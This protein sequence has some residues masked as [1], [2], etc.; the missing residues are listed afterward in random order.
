MLK[1]F[2][3]YDYKTKRESLARKIETYLSGMEVATVN[4]KMIGTGNLNQAIKARIRSCDA[5]I[6]MLTEGKDNDFV[7]SEMY[8]ADGRDKDIIIIT[9]G[10]VKELKKGLLADQAYIQLPKRK[11][12]LKL[13]LAAA[14]EKVKEN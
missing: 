4:G 14:V 3:A 6:S 2:L 12:E 10:D 1:F 7:Y 13:E 8:Y 11:D 9:Q 5:L